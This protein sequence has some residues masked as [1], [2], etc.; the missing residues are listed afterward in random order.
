MIL[1]ARALDAESAR[2]VLGDGYARDLVD[3]IDYDWGRTSVTAR[4]ASTVM[5]RAVQFDEW[6]RQFMAVHDEATVLHLGCGLDT[7]YQRLRPK[8]GIDWFD[9][10][11]PDVIALRE[12]FFQT[13]PQYRMIPASVTE[14]DWLA[15][16]RADRPVLMLAEGVTMYL[17]RDAGLELLRRVVSRFP[18]GEMQFDVFNRWAI[19]MQK[20]NPVMRRTGST[21]HW[22]I[23]DPQ[24]ILRRVPGTRLIAAKSALDPHSLRQ[25]TTGYRAARLMS[26][27]P[28][29][30]NLAQYHRYAF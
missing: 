25:L 22:G 19:R 18:S 4:N 15:S 27:L 7:R 12:N 1:H 29:F 23:D 3:R 2:P 6:A 14:L 24:D 30:K 16:I 21:L 17:R 28:G 20:V 8:P 26:L 11:L 5:I 9:V 10:D 13:N